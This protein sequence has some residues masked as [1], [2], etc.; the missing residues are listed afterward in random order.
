MGF[1]PEVRAI[2]SQTSSGLYPLLSLPST[3]ARVSVFTPVQAEATIY[4]IFLPEQSENQHSDQ[5]SLYCDCEVLVDF[6]AVK[7]LGVVIFF[8]SLCAYYK[9]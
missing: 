6:K 3:N 5:D 2:L 4:I 8:C 1:E 7:A 9:V